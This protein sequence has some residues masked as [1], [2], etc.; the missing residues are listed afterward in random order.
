M[1]F[2]TAAD[3]LLFLNIFTKILPKYKYGAFGSFPKSKVSQ[4]INLNMILKI[5][6]IAAF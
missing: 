3:I 6:N 4:Y 2:S 5:L 1:C